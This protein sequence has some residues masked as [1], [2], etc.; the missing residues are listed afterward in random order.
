MAP[1]K[2]LVI[3]TH[4]V[5]LISD[6]SH[7]YHLRDSLAEDHHDVQ[8]EDPDGLQD[9]VGEDARLEPLHVSRDDITEPPAPLVDGAAPPG[10]AGD[11][12][13]NKKN[14]RNRSF[15]ERVSSFMKNLIS[16]R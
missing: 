12:P 4:T 16:I 3:T 5:S 7:L 13:D 14:N 6:C 11:L 1:F 10:Q 2:K 15:K 8:P 9:S